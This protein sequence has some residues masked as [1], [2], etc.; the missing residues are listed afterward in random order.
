MDYAASLQMV[1]PEVILSLGSLVLLMIAAFAG[2]KATRA[3]GWLSVG[4]F[5]AA[6]LS[7]LGPAG[8]DRSL[9]ALAG[10]IADAA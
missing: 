6:G 2:D 3:I 10:R 5:A 9:I 8:T 4:L 1:L 7:L